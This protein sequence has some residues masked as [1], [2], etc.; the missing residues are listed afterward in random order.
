MKINFTTGGTLYEA[1]KNTIRKIDFKNLKEKNLVVVP[2]SFS[3][4]AES[5][6]FD[7]LNIKSSFNIAVVGISRLAS[8]ILKEHN[9]FYDRISG[10]EEI[11]LTYKAIDVNKEKFQYFQNFGVDFGMK[12]LKLLKQFSNC[13][14]KPNDIK[15]C[16]DK[17]LSAKMHDL[18][19]IYETYLNL[20]E[21]RLDLSKL[22][23]FFLEKSDFLDLSLYNLYFVNFDSFSTEIFEFICAL[24]GKVKSIHISISK[25]RKLGNAYIFEQDTV[26]KMFA[27][28]KMHNIQIE[29][30]EK[31]SNLTDEQSDVID[32]VFSLSIERAKTNAFHNIVTSTSFDELEFVAKYIRYKIHEGARFKDF[33]LALADE[34]Y[35][36]PLERVFERYDIPLYLDHTMSLGEVAYA[37]FFVKCLE[38]A[39]AGFTKTDL[40]YLVYSPF[41]KIE[42]REKILNDIDYYDIKNEN[43]IVEIIDFVSVIKEIS[44]EKNLK[45][46][47]TLSKKLLSLVQVENFLKEIENVQRHSEN[48]QAVDVVLGI[49]DEISNFNLDEEMKLS[50]FIFL[51]KTVFQSVKIET[52]PSFIDAVYAGDVTKSYFEDAS[53]LFV[54]GATASKLP[55]TEKD[56]GILTDEDLGKLSYKIEPEIRVINRRNRLKL[57]EALQHFKKELFVL[58]PL[59]QNEKKASFVEDLI[60]AF[61]KESVTNYASFSKFDR[62]DLTMEAKIKLA[63][64]NLGTTGVASQN[65]KKIENALPINLRNSIYKCCDDDIFSYSYIALP[66]SVINGKLSASRLE[67]YFSC[68]FKH[69]VANTLKVQEKQYAKEDKRK[70]G[71]LKHA[72]AQKFVEQGNVFKMT[73]KDINGF[74]EEYFSSTCHEVFEKISL[75]NK[76]FMAL[77]K[78]ECFNMLSNIVYE[79]VASEFKPVATEKR[80]FTSIAGEKFSGVIDRVDVYNNYFRIIDYKTGTVGSVLKDLA[81]GKKLQLFLYGM[82]IKENLKKECA[83]VYYFDCKNKFKKKNKKVKL[84]DGLT[85]KENEVVYATDVAFNEEGGKSNIIGGERK[86]DKGDFDFKYGRFVTNFDKLFDYA[87]KISENAVKEMKE[88]YIEPK[89]LGEACTYCKFKSICKFN[90]NAGRKQESKEF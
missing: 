74:L 90:E 75:E 88:G 82:V 13:K 51:I 37:K 73:D 22:L 11:L 72:L 38:I 7:A 1:G 16:D 83:G 85:L 23:A 19:L 24:T 15:E 62:A 78:R 64:F 42:N 29:V 61:G 89:P 54:L 80:V 70:I 40:E 6:I 12:I 21:E 59:G 14:L 55:R 28:A 20:L 30:D 4:Q 84:L 5:L 68:P 86:K 50:D 53:Y 27:L 56:Y 26:E 31:K 32:N 71:I 60:K 17:V 45:N 34:A 65:F 63:S 81:Y 47:C 39:E 76:T 3:M 9:I 44:H 41:L 10:L 69:F 58:T 25:P 46:L 48:E 35:I 57:F 79:Q 43:E 36:K 66:T 77:L 2:D 52:V 87:L 33:S 8:K 18:K 67:N 49:L